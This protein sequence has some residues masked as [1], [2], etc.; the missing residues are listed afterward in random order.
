M[1]KLQFL[2]Y[3]DF[4][5]LPEERILSLLVLASKFETMT[6]DNLV[7]SSDKVWLIS[8]RPS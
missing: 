2:P 5:G 8:L 6:L 1:Y 3:F 4:S 7:V